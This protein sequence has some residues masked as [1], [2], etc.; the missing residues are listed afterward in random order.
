MPGETSYLTVWLP[1]DEE[2]G[3]AL[4]PGAEASLSAK[5]TARRAEAART[6]L[7]LDHLYLADN[8]PNF[9][10]LSGR[11]TCAGTLGCEMNVIHLGFYGAGGEFLGAWYFTK[12]M[13]LEGSEAKDFVVQMRGLPLPSLSERAESVSAIGF[14]F[15]L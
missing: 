4:L 8:Y 14:G 10:T 7:T 11:I 6:L 15:S 13:L 9:T 5:L 2:A 1:Q 12:N 3:S